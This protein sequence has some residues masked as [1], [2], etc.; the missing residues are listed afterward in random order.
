[1]NIEKIYKSKKYIILAIL[2]VILLI[3]LGWI[4]IV[5]KR[6]SQAN[7]KGGILQE[8]IIPGYTEEQIKEI[9]QRK[10][11]ESPFSFEINSRPF[12]ENGK[13]EGNIRIYNPP[14]NNYLIDVEIKLDS[15]N[16]TIFKSGKLKPNQYIEKAKLSRN[17][18][19]GEYEATATISAYDPESEQLLGVS[20]AKLIIAIEN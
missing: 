17:L 13:S 7:I 15:N 20:V 16:K 18:K 2:L 12:F 9:L 1:M 10:A 11:D 3:V 14:F 19:K 4:F 8:G 6:Q 5:N